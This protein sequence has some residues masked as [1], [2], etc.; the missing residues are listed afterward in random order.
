MTKLLSSLLPFFVACC[1]GQ[2]RVDPVPVICEKR[3]PIQRG[4]DILFARFCSNGDELGSSGLVVDESKTTGI[5]VIHGRERNAN[6]YLYYVEQAA[7]SVGAID[8]T[9]I[10][11]PQFVTDEDLATFGLQASDDMYWS[12]NG[13]IQGDTSKMTRY[14]LTFDMSSF[15]VGDKI[16]EAMLNAYPNLS[17]L[18]VIGHSAGGQ[19]V[20]RYA[21]GSA[22]NATVN[23]SFEYVIANPSSFMYFTNERAETL[24][25]E[26]SV[27]NSST[28]AYDTESCPDY[29]EYKYGLDHM[30]HYMD[31]VGEEAL[32][33]NFKERSIVLYLGSGDNSHEHHLDS[34]CEADL[35]GLNRFERGLIFSRHVAK[36]F[37]EEKSVKIASGIGHDARAMF[38]A[39]C[40]LELLF[41]NYS[42][43]STTLGISIHHFGLA[44]FFF[45]L[46]VDFLIAD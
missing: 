32:F 33:N 18:K 41:E 12:N 5:L 25:G 26:F 3:F 19:W 29:N 9:I 6:E 27:P 34:S 30:N 43:G 36:V 11:A 24:S 38:Q 15:E 42:S 2:K 31:S 37:G 23:V 40:G 45:Y 22:Q 39:P 16:I 4:D 1:H 14:D 21:A 44:L 35:Q 20:Q 17:T 8:D 28:H 46:A 13:W 10:V 7:R